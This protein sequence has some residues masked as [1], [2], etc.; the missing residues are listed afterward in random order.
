MLKYIVLID[1]PIVT[2]M[3]L[4]KKF[5]NTYI[6]NYVCDRLIVELL[7]QIITFNTDVQLYLHNFEKHTNCIQ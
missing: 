5:D 6:I 7:S 4:Q 1:F 2:V 3:S